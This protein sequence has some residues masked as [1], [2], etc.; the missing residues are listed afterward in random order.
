MDTRKLSLGL[1]LLAG[2]WATPPQ[3]QVSAWGGTHATL[4]AAVDACPATGCKILLTDAEYRFSEPVSVRGKSNLAIVGARPDGKRPVLDL[5]P[6]SLESEEIPTLGGHAPSKVHP[7]VW[8][9][10][11]PDQVTNSDGSITTR[12]LGVVRGT[13]GTAPNFLLHPGRKP[14]GTVD[15]ARPGGWLLS[16]FS[17]EH[18]NDSVRAMDER[19]GFLHPALIQVERSRFV[20]LEG[21]DFD[22]GVP[23]EYLVSGIWNRM[24]D[25]YSGIAAVGLN[26]SLQAT[27]ADCE[28]RG[29]AMGIRIVDRNEGGL[30]SD[31]MSA[32]GSS[33]LAHPL[34]N[35]GA[36][37][38]HRIEG[39]LAHGNRW[40]LHLERAW[41]LASS[42]RFNRVWDNGISRLVNSIDPHLSMEEWNNQIGGFCFL[43][44]VVYPSNV[45]QGNTLSRNTMDL[46]YN[47]WRASGYQLF[48]D[49]I[50]VR[51]ERAEWRE[52]T[53][54]L[55]NNRRN[56]WIAMTRQAAGWGGEP[57]DSVVPFCRNSGCDPLTP[58]WGAPSIDER[59]VGKG[60]FG[61]DLGSVWSVPRTSEIV[62]I[63]D[64]TLGF[65][66]RGAS[67]WRVILP[68]PVQAAPFVSSMTVVKALAQK[69]ALEQVGGGTKMDSVL[70]SLPSL[71]G[72]PAQD[73]INLFEFEIP[74]SADDSIWRVEMVVQGID[75]NTG[76]SVH[77]NLGNWLV[78]PLGKQLLVATDTSIVEPGQQVR[79][80]V[81]VKDS[82]G[83]QAD[84]ESAPALNAQGWTLD[85]KAPGAPAAG[86]KSASSNRFEIVATA[87]A[88][89]G[90]SQV[91]F[92]SAEKGR[93]Q[94]VSGA[95]YVKV[96][97]RSTG[98]ASR[99]SGADWRLQGISRSANRWSVRIAGGVETHL[100]RV[101]LVDPAGRRQIV[102]VRREGNGSVLEFDIGR[103]GTHFLKIGDRA[104][105]VALVP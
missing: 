57:G 12:S 102:S 54:E 74:A 58:V 69:I 82:L 35:P 51:Q 60:Y 48:F 33:P 7:W 39:N 71:N 103:A 95:A 9:A 97:A 36:S 77:S 101:F 25:Q 24:Y 61:D 14:D 18:V 23:V 47:G 46:G 44:D 8:R 75:G 28:F 81:E 40:F 59:V 1:V 3:F 31:L 96:A 11:T 100:S 91:V 53:R 16:P 93:V 104:I 73:G 52:L 10:S 15:P 83:N 89:E 34:S 4:Q 86:R 94:A 45:F 22:G 90:V 85:A 68:V 64:Q 55:G 41:D 26:N 87:P 42:I 43:I 105:P 5:D 50:S 2:A 78:R 56:N 13:A 67:G 49:N 72:R 99:G 70:T 37:G 79:F 63:Q 21:L 38:G 62:Q 98:V 92:W 76:R 27:V 20:R 30:V 6:A 32:E 80:V 88:A 65:A 66:T 84:L 29:W 17:Y 19:E